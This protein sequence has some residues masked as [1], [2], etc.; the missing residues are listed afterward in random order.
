M[1]HL[2]SPAGQAALEAIVR[3]RPLLAFD[4]DGTLAPIVAQPEDVRL[5]PEVAQRLA[6][7]AQRLPL[8]VVTGRRI[9]DVRGR[10]GFEPGF[11]VGSHGAEDEDGSALTPAMTAALDRVRKRIDAYRP[12]LRDAGVTVEDKGT[13]LA[14]HYRLSRTRDRALELMREL[15]GPR[16]DELRVF[17]GKMVVNVVPRHAPDKADAVR[18]LLARCGASCAL[19]AG[20]DVNDEPVFAAA[21]ADWL[22]IH[23]GDGGARSRARYFVESPAEVAALLGRIEA[24]LAQ[25]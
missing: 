8:A 15:L 5:P 3:R 10:L 22:T 6:A 21:P 1:Q 23:V 13:S 20:D 14:L 12:A 18:S 24:L 2:F 4:F 7:L 25:P 16:D 19:F 9:D 17:G 11:I